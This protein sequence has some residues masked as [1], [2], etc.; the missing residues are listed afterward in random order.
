L[1]GKIMNK[2][3]AY[4]ML[5]IGVGGF[6]LYCYKL[7]G[8]H[9]EIRQTERDI[10]MLKTLGSMQDAVLSLLKK[11]SEKEIVVGKA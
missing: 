3:L 2:V 5:T 6:G 9:A 11:T 7:G 1:K 4:I 10:D 8:I